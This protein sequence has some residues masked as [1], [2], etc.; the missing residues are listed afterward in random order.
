MNTTKVNRFEIIDHSQCKYCEGRG[1]LPGGN[2]CVRCGGVGCT[3]RE[4]VL[5]DDTKQVDVELQD[6]G[7]TLKIFIHERYADE[8]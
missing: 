1:E 5:W 3:G 8:S 2:Q 6:D 4:V 7:K